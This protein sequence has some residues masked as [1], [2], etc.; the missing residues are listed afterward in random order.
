MFN[1]GFG[2]LTLILIIVAVVFGSIKLPQL[3]EGRESA[4]KRYRAGLDNP[5][6]PRLL[7]QRRAPRRWTLS[8]WALLVAAAGLMALAIANAAMRR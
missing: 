4:M 6:P 5:E 3:R 8:D 2:E 7:L 1:L